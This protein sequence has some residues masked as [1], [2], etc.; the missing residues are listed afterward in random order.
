MINGLNS[1]MPIDP[2]FHARTHGRVSMGPILLQGGS[3]SVNTH[4]RIL[5]SLSATRKD[6]RSADASKENRIPGF[7]RPC[8]TVTVPPSQ[9]WSDCQSECIGAFDTPSHRHWY[10][11]V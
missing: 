5:N 9:I 2:R 10:P 8:F 7:K 4:T 11:Q 3:T 1:R 6:L